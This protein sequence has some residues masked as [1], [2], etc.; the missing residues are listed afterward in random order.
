MKI[1][2]TNEKF[3]ILESEDELL[4]MKYTRQ[5]QNRVESNSENFYPV[6]A[7]GFFLWYNLIEVKA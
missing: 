1:E 2:E 5:V 3:L 4:E 6:E 7:A